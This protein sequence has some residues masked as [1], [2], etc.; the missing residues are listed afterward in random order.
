M[1]EET[2]KRIENIEDNLDKVMLENRELEQ[3]I[4]KLEAK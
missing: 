3:R 4:I 1:E 2:E